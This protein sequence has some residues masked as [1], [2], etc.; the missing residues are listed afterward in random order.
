[1]NWNIDYLNHIV[2]KPLFLFIKRDAV[3]NMASLFKTRKIFF[4]DPNRWY[5]FKP[6]EYETLKTKNV[7]LQLAG[8]VYY[9]NK[10]IEE[11]LGNIQPERRIT[12]SYEK[13]C[14]APEHHYN[15][16][17]Y[18]LKHHG[19]SIDQV[20][21]GPPSFQQSL[22]FNDEFNV[23]KAEKALACIQRS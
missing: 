13:F 2:Q 4:N 15:L 18:H 12:I 20:Y 3:N 7:Y 21:T 22:N 23:A 8:Q 16:I 9:T 6:P 1:M 14:K 11:T 17:V 10:Y 19:Y 5:S